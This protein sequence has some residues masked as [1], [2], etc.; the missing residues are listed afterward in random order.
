MLLDSIEPYAAIGV[1][2]AMVLIIAAGMLI[3]A[4]VIGPRRHGPVKDSPYESGVPIVGDTRRRMHIRFYIVAILFLL[5]D[6]ELVLL[7]PWATIFYQCAVHGETIPL[8]GGMV[9]GKEFLLVG[10]GMFVSLVV[11]GLLYEWKKGAFRWD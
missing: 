8:D 5:F 1:T 3:L 2:V 9:A 10:M 11:F 7:W 4:H 6:V